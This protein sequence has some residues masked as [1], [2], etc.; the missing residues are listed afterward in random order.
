MGLD[1]INVIPLIPRRRSM[2]LEGR[3]YRHGREQCN[4]PGL[5]DTKLESAIPHLPSLRQSLKPSSV[6]Q[7]YLGP[8]FSSRLRRQTASRRQDLAILSSYLGPF[9]LRFIDVVTSC[10]KTIVNRSEE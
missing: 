7:E 8:T 4:R 1:V 2:S 6:I 5:T 3:K 10:V 9:F